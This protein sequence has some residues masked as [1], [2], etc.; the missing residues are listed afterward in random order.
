MKKFMLILVL[1]YSFIF[2]QAQEIEWYKCDFIESRSISKG[3]IEWSEWTTTDV[4]YFLCVDTKEGVVKFDNAAKTVIT[5]RQLITSEVKIDE[6]K[7]ESYV[8]TYSAFDEEGISC[9]F[10]SIDYTKTTK[11]V[12]GVVYSNAQLL[13]YCTIVVNAPIK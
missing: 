2:V 8:N 4:K 13:W 5:V 1:V 3:E 12:F 10:V 9:S 6:D 11:R 7:G